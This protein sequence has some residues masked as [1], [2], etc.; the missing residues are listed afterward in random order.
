[1]KRLG[2]AGL[3]PAQILECLKKLHPDET[4]LA[5]IDTIYSA[6]KRA[7]QE[8][9]QGISPIIHLNEI[10]A[11]TDFTTMTKVD[12]SGELKGLFFCHSLSVK[13][14]HQYHLILFLDCTYKTNKYWMPLLHITGVTGA[15][16]SFSLAFCFLAKETQDYYD[17][18]LESLLKVFTSNKIPL[19]A[20]VLTN[21]EEA[22]ISSIQSNFPDLTHMLC[23]WHITYRRTWSPMAQNTSRTRRRSSK[24]FNTGA[25]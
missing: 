14:L 13:L 9:L 5:T 2:E 11:G 20:V 15:N 6:Q 16:K 1:M 22:L 19:P 18:A 10:L 17:W 21:Q 8:M 23:T 4:I 3:R 25:T 24:C 12:E 7:A